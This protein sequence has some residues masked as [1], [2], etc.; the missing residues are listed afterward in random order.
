M[1]TS[2]SILESCHLAKEKC[3][4]EELKSYFIELYR[5]ILPLDFFCFPSTLC[6]IV[7]RQHFPCLIFLVA[8]GSHSSGQPLKPKLKEDW[9][10]I[11]D[12]IT[13]S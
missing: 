5:I 2:E 3:P 11:Q 6:F 9:N 8:Q 10:D 7:D 1:D 13:E 12:G 4:F